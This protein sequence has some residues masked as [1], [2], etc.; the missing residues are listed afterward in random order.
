LLRAAGGLREATTLELRV[1]EQEFTGKQMMII[2]CDRYG[3]EKKL[4]LKKADFEGRMRKASGN[5][6]P[7]GKGRRRK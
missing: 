1:P 6:T 5:R 4:V 3:N 7:A 2:L